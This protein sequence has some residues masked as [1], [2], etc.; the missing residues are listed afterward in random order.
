MQQGYRRD[1]SEEVPQDHIAKCE[2]LKQQEF[3]FTVIYLIATGKYN[4]AMT[5]ITSK[6]VTQ[7]HTALKTKPI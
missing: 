5:F 4:N 2:K 6:N 7:Q 1:T 3:I